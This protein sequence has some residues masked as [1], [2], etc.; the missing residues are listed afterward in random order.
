MTNISHIVLETEH[1]LYK[2]L[3]DTSYSYIFC[4]YVLFVSS[5]ANSEYKFLNIYNIPHK[6]IYNQCQ[7]AKV[8]NVNIT[9]LFVIDSYIN[10]GGFSNGKTVM[11][12]HFYSN[13]NYE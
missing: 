5:F 9:H 8:A 2:Q 13:V 7:C 1:K 12:H 4:P 10:E 6:V 11:I 3:D